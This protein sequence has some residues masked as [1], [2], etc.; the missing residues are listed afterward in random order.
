MTPL[1]IVDSTPLAPPSRLYQISASPETIKKQQHTF[2]PLSR[3][4]QECG[5]ISYLLPAPYQFA[6]ATKFKTKRLSL[7][8]HKNWQNKYSMHMVHLCLGDWLYTED[9]QTYLWIVAPS[10]HHACI[11]D[12]LHSRDGDGSLSNIRG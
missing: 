12:I 9:I 4:D 2:T 8:I 1:Y 11:N 5:I 6:G 10:L 7:T 3:Y